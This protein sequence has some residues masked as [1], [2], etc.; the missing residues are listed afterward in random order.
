MEESEDAKKRKEKSLALQA[1]QD[2]AKFLKKSVG[3]D[4]D[5]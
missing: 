4:I 2:A 1:T 5:Y 3:N